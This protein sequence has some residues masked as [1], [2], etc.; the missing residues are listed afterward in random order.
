MPKQAPKLSAIQVDRLTWGTVKGVRKSGNQ[1]QIGEPC[2]AYHAVGGVSGLLLQ[3]RPPA[4]GKS[5]GSRSW[6][7]R[8]M[9]GSKRRMIGLGGY[10]DVTLA[11]ARERAREAKDKIRQ[12]I[13]PVTEKKALRSALIAEQGK[14]V[15]FRDLAQEYIAKKAK[16]YKTVKQVQKLTTQLERY[17]FPVI[18]DMVLTDIERAHIVKM[19]EP[20]WE[21]KN[22]T[23]AR[24]RLNTERILDL[25]GVKGLRTGD[26]PAR[27][28]GNLALTFA[29]REKVAKVQ[30][31]NSLEVKLMPE[32]WEKLKAQEWIGAKALQ[33]IIL[34][35]SRSGEVRGARWD[36]IDLKR[37]VW[38]IPAERMKGGRAHTVPLTDDAITLLESLPQDS[39]H[40]FTGIRG[41]ALTD[42]TISKVP[43]RIGYNVT[44]HGFRATFRTWAQEH[45]AYPEEVCELAL[46]HVNSD[47]TRA[48][49]ARGE[50]VDKRRKLM[51]D[52]HRF[53]N[54]GHTETADNVVAI[55]GGAV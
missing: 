21:T 49:Y 14:S 38:T 43:K 33:F 44:A 1:N 18:G 15:T 16:E 2:T 7:L 34:T 35:T 50:L 30:H 26:N 3:C 31:Y 53:C 48:A 28:N 13:D 5:T 12:G 11:Q 51:E 55:G 36:E 32:F 24:V 27:W 23:A 42:A 45:T 52:W 41:G 39:D 37:K 20:I 17:A 40:V 29:R 8:T 54:H 25:A 6:L 47:A 46:A 22:E 9:V 19:I 4:D 10:P